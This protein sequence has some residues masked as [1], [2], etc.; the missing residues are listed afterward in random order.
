[1]IELKEENSYTFEIYRLDYYFLKEQT[2][3]YY[4]EF[5]NKKVTKVSKKG[6]SK[7]YS[8]K[9]K[10]RRSVKKYLSEN[11]Y[12]QNLLYK[13]FD[14]VY[15]SLQGL[16]EINYRYYLVL[17]G[18]DFNVSSKCKKTINY[19]R[20]KRN[21]VYYCDCSLCSKAGKGKAGKA[22]L[23]SVKWKSEIKLSD[24]YYS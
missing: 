19:H 17:K 23:S 11:G 1:M 2:K 24:N 6:F 18:D 20:K 5:V 9:F 14:H 15:Q 13:N 4:G 10:S 16:S 7:I 8:K 22:N 21:K 12:I 3:K